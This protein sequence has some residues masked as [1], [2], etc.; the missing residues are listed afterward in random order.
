MRGDRQE[1]GHL[2]VQSLYG[3]LSGARAKSCCISGGKGALEPQGCGAWTGVEVPEPGSCGAPWGAA[4]CADGESWW[5]LI[6]VGHSNKQT[7]STHRVHGLMATNG[8]T[9]D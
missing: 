2:P 5:M 7:L 6:G 4:D 1:A 9:R 3:R 8:R